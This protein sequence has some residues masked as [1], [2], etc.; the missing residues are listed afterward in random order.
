MNLRAFSLDISAKLLLERPGFFEQPGTFRL[1]IRQDHGILL[2]L[3]CVQFYYSLGH[4][5]LIPI[6]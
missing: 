1:N 2:L 5:L 4:P 6:Y 3:I